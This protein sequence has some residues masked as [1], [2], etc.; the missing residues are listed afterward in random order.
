MSGRYSGTGFSYR[1]GKTYYTPGKKNTSCQKIFFTI[2][3]ALFL[4]ICPIVLFYAEYNFALLVAAISEVGPDVVE[5]DD[6]G[7]VPWHGKKIVHTTG[8]VNREAEVRDD[9]FHV[10]VGP[11]LVM[12]RRTEYCQ[13]MEHQREECETCSE[14]TQNSD[15]SESE[16]TYKCNCVIRYDYTK[17]WTN[18]RINSLLF[19]QPAAHYNPQRD[20]FP[21]QKI[22]SQNA[23]V[24][25]FS[26][27]PA[28]IDNLKAQTFSIDWNEEA[29][30]QDQW[31][32]SVWLPIKSYFGFQKTHYRHLFELNSVRSSRAA[33]DHAF[34]Y[35]GQGGYFF[36]PYTP[37]NQER[38]LK[39]MGQALEGSLL[40]WQVGDFF[41]CT[42]GDIRVSYS[43]KLPPMV[44]A[45]GFSKAQSPSDVRQSLG[46]I[47]TQGGRKQLGLLHEGEVD[48]ESM[49]QREVDEERSS[50]RLVR[51]FFFLWAAV[52][53]DAI[54]LYCGVVHTPLSMG[55]AVLGVWGIMLSLTRGVSD[56]LVSFGVMSSLFNFVCASAMLAASVLYFPKSLDG[57]SGFEPIKRRYQW[58][59][60]GET[61]VTTKPKSNKKSL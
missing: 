13:W 51:V 33:L 48:S 31:Y 29:Q 55:I 59:F 7:Q 52:V 9:A 42:P 23:Q 17:G 5:V 27:D 61:E 56:Y 49:F 3:L 24:N 53:A 22:V 1:Q 8:M 47:N 18:F 30:R 2:L 35:I 4:I 46:L 37:S 25:G 15:G 39:W 40:D 38:V 41:G 32:D 60:L 57:L 43:A 26:L 20:P 58:I 44:S 36:S 12:N 50:L 6:P 28:L 34:F 19:N 11:A 21:S 45:L 16:R 54:L 10:R 14:T